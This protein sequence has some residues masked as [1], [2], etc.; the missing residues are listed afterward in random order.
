M[1]PLGDSSHGTEN[2]SHHPRSPWKGR[3]HQKSLC[4]GFLDL[5]VSAGIGN[6]RDALAFCPAVPYGKGGGVQS[7]PVQ[8][9]GCGF[10]LMGT[11]CSAPVETTIVAPF[12]CSPLGIMLRS[13]SALLLSNVCLP[14]CPEPSLEMRAVSQGRSEA[15]DR[16][17]EVRTYHPFRAGFGKQL[18]R[19][20]L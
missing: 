10:I 5:D 17:S 6:C 15:Q 13:G 16:L 7:S 18:A 12:A 20:E 2:C 3:E 11:V 8:Q 4:L 19:A 14:F 9:E 1:W